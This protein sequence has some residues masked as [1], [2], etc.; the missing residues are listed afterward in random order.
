MYKQTDPQYKAVPMGFGTGSIYQYGCYLV[1]FVNGLN[2][3][4]Y[5]FA[6][7]SMNEML[8]THGAWVGP[9]K[10]YIDTP[11]LHRYFPSVFNSFNK[12]NPWNDVPSTQ[13]LL[14]PNLVVV[15]RVDA[16][17]IGG[18]GTHYV[19]LVGIQDGIAVINDPWTGNTEKI[20]VRYGNYGNILSVDVFDVN[21]YITPKP[22]VVTPAPQPPTELVPQ[23]PSPTPAAAPDL[24]PM[25]TPEPVPTPASL[26]VPEPVP[27][28][29]APEPTPMPTDPIAAPTPAAKLTLLQVILNFIYKLFGGKSE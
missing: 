28:V 8:K 6:P 16:R 20:T 18:S 21:P 13:D 26:P 7:I 29:L 11:N 1:S 22:V 17:A 2:L 3:K 27:P 24:V 15:C 14:K 10:N 25:P 5:S 4:N 12:I 9:Y 23:E 19:C